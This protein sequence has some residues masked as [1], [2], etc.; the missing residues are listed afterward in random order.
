MHPAVARGRPHVWP[1]REVREVTGEWYAGRSDIDF[2]AVLAERP[3]EQVV[4][5][6]LRAFTQANLRE[7]WAPEAEQLRRFPAEAARPDRLAWSCSAPAGC[8]TCSP[9]TG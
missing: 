7:Y 9:P 8:T 3:D 6:A 2:V 1:P 4:D 5:Q